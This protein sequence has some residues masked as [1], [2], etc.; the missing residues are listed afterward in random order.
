[1]SPSSTFSSFGSTTSASSSSS[2]AFSAFGATESRPVTYDGSSTQQHHHRLASAADD[3]DLLALFSSDT[4]SLESQ[5]DRD[6]VRLGSFL[7]NLIPSAST[8][9]STA[10]QPIPTGSSSSFRAPSNHQFGSPM[11]YQSSTS[12][13]M[14]VPPAPSSSLNNHPTRTIPPAP[15]IDFSNFNGFGGWGKELEGFAGK[16]SS[17][18][19]QDRWNT[20]GTPRSGGATPRR[21]RSSGVA[22]NAGLY[23]STTWRVQNG[24][25][26]RGQ[27]STGGEGESTLGSGLQDVHESGQGWKSRLRKSTQQ[28][29]LAQRI[30]PTRGYNH[31]PDPSHRHPDDDDE[32]DGDEDDDDGGGYTH[33][34]DDAEGDDLMMDD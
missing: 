7:T 9:T 17:S 10:S 18:F 21:R 34:G 1:M 3:D 27:S 22:T 20:A 5:R 31:D 32:E 30:H 2:S 12:S 11:S 25:K 24:S 14:N 26:G 19:N 8:S 29:S 23:D 15:M 6:L 16:E 28:Q 13:G 33:Q 4:F